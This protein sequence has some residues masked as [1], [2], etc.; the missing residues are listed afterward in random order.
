MLAVSAARGRNM[1]D[2]FLSYSRNDQDAVGRLKAAL[3]AAG[4]TVWLDTSAIEP[5]K[6]IGLGIA[7]A[8][9]QSK[10]FLAHY[11][12][13]YPKKR[14]CQWELT[15]AWL[16]AEVEGAE[17]RRVLVINPE[18]AD[19]GH[20][21]P[22]ALRDHAFLGRD[23]TAAA[24]VVKA[25]AAAFATPLG[26][27][28]LRA[29]PR[30]F[31][32]HPVGASQF[33]GR[34]HELWYVHSLLAAGTVTAIGAAGH[35]A[36]PRLG[37]LQGM[38]GIG[39]SLLAQEYA[40]R[41]GAGYPGGV[42]WL[43]CTEGGGGELLPPER[44]EA[45]RTDQMRSL[46]I[47]LGLDGLKE[48]ELDA[49]IADALA[50]RSQPFLWI[51][52]DW[53]Q[54]SDNETLRK[55]TAPVP[56]LGRTLVTTRSRLHRNI[57]TTLRLTTLDPDEAYS[58]LTRTAEPR[59]PADRDAA[60]RITER[61]GCHALAV[62][63]AGA[64][65]E[66]LGY[67]AFLAMLDQPG[68]A[69]D[70][71]AELA[72]DLPNGHEKSVFRTLAHSIKLLS[73]P[74]R[75]ALLLA[76]DLAAAPVP[77]D[78]VVMVL[79][80]AD[81]LSKPEATKRAA[82]GI[83]AAKRLSLAEEAGPQAFT[84]HVLVTAALRHEDAFVDRREHLRSAAVLALNAALRPAVDDNR[85][86]PKIAPLIPHA[87]ALTTEAA[88]AATLDLLE[89]VCRYD[90]RRGA[91]AAA[92]HAARRVLAGRE[93]LLGAE[94]PNTLTAI[95]NLAVI[96]ME[97]KELTSA[98]PALEKA[99]ELWK[100][101]SGPEHPETLTTMS[102]LANTLRTLGD[103]VAARTLHEQTLEILKRVRGADHQSTLIS[104]T[105]LAFTLSEQ[106]DLAGARELEEQALDASKRVLGADH[107]ET[108]VRL[109]NLAYTL[110]DLGEHVQ[111][112]ELFE[113]A[114]S[115]RRRVLTDDHP[116]TV[117]TFLGLA[118]LLAKMGEDQARRALLDAAPE[119]ARRAG[120]VGS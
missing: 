35:A 17:T 94:H 62:D 43:R 48:A 99:L 20:I 8:I 57:G 40:L 102:N 97:L 25:Q 77:L 36:G 73:E 26:E 65:V 24:A 118:N 111:A 80:Q 30:W 61:L 64:A 68:D 19:C 45:L 7:A 113:A 70:L 18:P 49:R 98:R 83:E 51:L 89:I 95:N 47:T 59:T 104:M 32:T 46:A 3:E 117:T 115:G 10:V 1:Q 69:L 109:N 86:H 4:L 38:G 37:Q 76:A 11:S 15:T 53:P 119:L 67:P 21:F 22:S 58:L 120:L 116:Y 93:V 33:V 2:V 27:I 5:A 50:A 52:D 90:L 107:P 96:F 66:S 34:L 85:K 79:E 16:A 56:A 100:R 54:D 114:L 72:A 82:L 110:G 9:A 63:V 74:G 71:A 55:W 39:K 60:R 42:V 88:D 14:Y 92:A 13:S 108:L 112:R 6:P 44:L 41:F 106:G 81:G 101:V 28:A 78:P 29:A 75:D 87:R 91:Y 103:L 12:H 84:L 31:G 23:P 105:S